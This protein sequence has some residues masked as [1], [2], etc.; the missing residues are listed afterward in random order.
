MDASSPI[1]Q[2]AGRLREDLTTEKEETHA[3][4][5]VWDSAVVIL[6]DDVVHHDTTLLRVRFDLPSSTAWSV[7]VVQEPHLKYIVRLRQDLI[8]DVGR[9]RLQRRSRKASR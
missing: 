2:H 5:V 8:C 9:K 1:K 3:V 6:K 4:H 7:R